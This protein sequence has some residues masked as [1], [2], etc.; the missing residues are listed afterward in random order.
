[1]KSK[2]FK[3]TPAQDSSHGSFATFAIP[4]LT[5]YLPLWISKMD[6]KLKNVQKHY[7]HFWHI[8]WSIILHHLLYLSS[9]NIMSNI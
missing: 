5:K 8:A 6:R 9:H 4:A 7:I 2:L 1:M 3:A